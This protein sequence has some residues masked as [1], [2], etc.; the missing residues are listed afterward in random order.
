MYGTDSSGRSPS[1]SN[2]KA[3]T[4]IFVLQ[5]KIKRLWFFRYNGKHLSEIGWS[6]YSILFAKY[7][8]NMEPSPGTLLVKQVKPAHRIKTQEI[9]RPIGCKIKLVKGAFS[10]SYIKECP[11]RF[12]IKLYLV[13]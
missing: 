9:T 4:L 6:Q 1:K 3:G 13:I 2:G 8:F 5:G 12:L 7:L 10:G 11:V